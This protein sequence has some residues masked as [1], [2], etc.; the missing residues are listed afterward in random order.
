MLD[1]AK[2]VNITVFMKRAQCTGEEALGWSETYQA[3]VAEINKIDE[4]EKISAAGKAVK[5]AVKK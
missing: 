5:Q 4:A 3:V 2:L 1:R